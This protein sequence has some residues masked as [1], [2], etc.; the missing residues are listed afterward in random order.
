MY[1]VGR[2]EGNLKK[3][4]TR[5]LYNYSCVPNF[6]FSTFITNLSMSSFSNFM[7][8]CLKKAIYYTSAHANF[9]YSDKIKFSFDSYKIKL[10]LD[11]DLDFLIAFLIMIL[12]KSS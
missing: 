9:F 1:L 7:P 10:D 11:F 8:G 4:M 6:R 2:V 5:Q 3:D 12:S